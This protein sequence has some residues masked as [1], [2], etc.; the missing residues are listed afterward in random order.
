MK[1]KVRVPNIN[2]GKVDSI[3]YR[4]GLDYIDNYQCENYHYKWFVY[5]VK[6]KEQVKV[7]KTLGLVSRA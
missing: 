3:Y 2:R 1:V 7:L 5:E 4:Y 6:T